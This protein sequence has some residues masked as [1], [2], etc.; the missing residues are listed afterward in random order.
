MSPA[1]YPAGAVVKV[2]IGTSYRYFTSL[3]DS[4]TGNDPQG[5]NGTLWWI[6]T[7]NNVPQ[8]WQWAV[9]AIVQTPEGT[10]IETLPYY[11][12]QY[13]PDGSYGSATPLPLSN[14]CTPEQPISLF[15]QSNVGSGGV[16]TSTY[17]L[18]GVRIYKEYL[19]VVRHA[20]WWREDGA[21]RSRCLRRPIHQLTGLRPLH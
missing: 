4:N 17:A 13:T 2:G 14:T 8:Q 7:S 1:T 16:G 11:V 19:A 12:T 3:Q 21:H 5:A 20:D 18:W 15:Y 9:T 6:E 10:M